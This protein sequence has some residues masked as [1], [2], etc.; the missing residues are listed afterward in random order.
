[1]LFAVLLL[2]HIII[3]LLVFFG[4]RSGLLKV[5]KVMF[6]VALLLPFWGVLTVMVLHLQIGFKLDDAIDVGVEKLKLESELYK[7]VTIDEKKV[8]AKTV[9]IEE[10][11]VINSPRE[12]RSIIMDVLNDNPKEYIEFLQKAG[13]NEDTEVVHYAVTAMVEISKENDY[14][15]QQFEKRY[16]QNPEDLLV[17]ED[18]ANF[19]WSCI[20]QNLMQGQVMIM[21]RKLYSELMEKKISVDPTIT[22]F[23]RLITNELELKN[24]TEASV[25]LKKFKQTYPQSEDYYL[26]RLKYLGSL[27]RGEDIKKLINEIES[28]EIFFSSRA[29]EELAFWKE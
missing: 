1:M 17:L 15:L 19:L 7:T 12:R 10:A 21:N 20:S 8:A 9:P 22:D 2:L 3:S 13:N 24:Y 16:S 5:H 27:N 14:R 26:M 6:W 29:K 25:Y 28:E 11:L 18:Y 4:I 23:V